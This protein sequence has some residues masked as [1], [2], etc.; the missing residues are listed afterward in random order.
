MNN[1]LINSMSVI[2]VLIT[3]LLHVSRINIIYNLI[4]CEINI[5]QVSVFV[6]FIFYDLIIHYCE[7]YCYY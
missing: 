1:K 4:P 5:L 7:T 3:F 6:L 2:D